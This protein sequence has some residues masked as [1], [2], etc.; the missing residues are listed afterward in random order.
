MQRKALFYLVSLLV[1]LSMVLTACGGQQ[2]TSGNSDDLVSAAKAEGNL[3]VIALAHSW[4]NYGEAIEAFKA[5][6]GIAVNEL[7]PDASS[8]D[9][10]EAIKANKDNKGPQAPD[11]IDVGYSFGPQL[12][13]E[14][15]EWLKARAKEVYDMRG[16]VREALLM[17][18]SAIET[19]NEKP[20]STFK[21]IRAT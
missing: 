18:L 4:C 1:V 21:C 20:Q 9:E 12:I 2:T 17:K 13:E 19:I 15:R 3:T 10:I 8:G 5:K 16:V 6:Y 11:V 7:N 14:K